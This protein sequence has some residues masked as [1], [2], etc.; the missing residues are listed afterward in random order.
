MK[1]LIVSALCFLFIAPALGD[2]Q[3]FEND[4]DGFM[5]E[6]GPLSIIDFETLPDGQP[7]MGGEELT[8][9]FNYDAQGV[10]FSAPFP[11]PFIAGNPVT[12]F[13][14]AVSASQD[15][16]IIAELIAPAYAVGGFFAG[17]TELC[18]FD[19]LGSEIACVSFNQSGEGN[20][21]GIVATD[22]IY[23][24]VF[25]EGAH[26]ERIESFIFSPVPEPATL[27]LLASAAA[28]MVGRR[29]RAAI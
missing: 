1:K 27:A 17:A 10:H 16:W 25:S 15:T 21:V 14:L 19:Q 8:D 5:Q 2:V 4:F 26:S 9:D 11:Y 29:R 6:A 24:A 23:S 20:F 13:E 3:T 22:P 12:G 28:L 18:A 7:S